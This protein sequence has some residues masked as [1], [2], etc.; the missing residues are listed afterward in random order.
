MQLLFTM[1]ERLAQ[2]DTTVLLL[3]ETGTGKTAVANAVHSISRRRNEEFVAINCAGVAPQVAESE[4]FGH[5]KGAFTGACNAHKGI[6]EQAQ[7]G[8]VL[9]DEI[10]DMSLDLQ[11]KLLQVLESRRVRPVG[12]ERDIPVDFRLFCATNCDLGAAIKAGRF[13]E[14]LFHR[15][16]TISINVPALR[17]RLSDLP[18]LVEYLMKRYDRYQDPARPNR[19]LKISN[20][21]MEVL[22]RYYWPGNV[23]ELDNVLQRAMVLTDSDE[24]GPDDILTTPWDTGVDGQSASTEFRPPDA[25]DDV[26]SF[27]DYRAALLERHD[28][29]VPRKAAG[30]CRRQCHQGGVAKRAVASAFTGPVAQVWDGVGPCTEATVRTWGLPVAIPVATWPP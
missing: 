4:L 16:S 21:A 11:A 9:L 26:I 22:A 15:I 19:V 10:G 7:G 25:S 3:G 27:R 1:V 5:V 17:D 13:R 23:R 2:Q 20:E 18:F 24:I 8:S 14:D 6:F 30:S 29:L 28:R 12:G